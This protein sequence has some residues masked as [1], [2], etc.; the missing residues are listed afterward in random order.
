MSA[1]T[2]P[3]P[4]AGTAEGTRDLGYAEAMRDIA[5]LAEDLLAGEHADPYADALLPVE[6]L[7]AIRSYAFAV[8]AMHAEARMTLDNIGWAAGW[9]IQEMWRRAAR[10][11]AAARRASAADT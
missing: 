4:W 1:G 5:H 9:R 2:G 10:C 8:F 11:G 3:L 6:A 7:E